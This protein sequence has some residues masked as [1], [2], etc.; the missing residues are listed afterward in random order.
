[1]G[2]V[3]SPWSRARLTSPHRPRS[4]TV[5]SRFSGL[6]TGRVRAGIV[7][8]NV[9]FYLT[10]GVA[11]A[12]L[13][14]IWTAS[15][16]LPSPIGQPIINEW[17]WGGVVGIGGEW[18]WSGRVSLRSEVLFVDIPD[19]KMRV[20]LSPGS[21]VPSNSRRAGERCTSIAKAGSTSRAWCLLRFAASLY[22]LWKWLW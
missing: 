15:E 20:P 18:A 22:E 10:G 12:R 11:A 2:S 8:E 1:M 5:A 3:Q 4:Q 6:V 7:I 21:S 19:R 13:Q 9:L 17:A 16:P 14:T